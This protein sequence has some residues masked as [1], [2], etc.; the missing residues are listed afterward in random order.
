MNILKQFL[1][2][3]SE[4]NWQQHGTIT[5][6]G[7]SHRRKRV[8]NLAR[9]LVNVDEETRR[10][11]GRPGGEKSLSNSGRPMAEFS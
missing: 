7:F 8:E 6:F 10:E 11:T 1:T 2:R 3:P 9:A 4:D 5:F